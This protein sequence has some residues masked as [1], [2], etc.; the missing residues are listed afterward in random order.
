MDD[1]ELLRLASQL[2]AALK[3]RGLKMTLAESCT[4]G[5]ASQF[6]TAVAGSSAWFDCGFVTYSNAAK[7][8]LLGVPEATLI[9]H[10]AVSEQTAYAMALGAISN[11]RAD[12]AASITGIAGPSGGTATKPIGTVCFAF[13][14]KNRQMPE[15]A[16]TQL[17]H[18]AANQTN[19]QVI[20]RTICFTGN[21]D[22]IRKQSVTQTLESLITLTL[23]LDL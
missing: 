13:A 4:G 18:L 19:L 8:H 2:G 12:I 20:T 16:N 7:Q 17:S 14:F 1:D 6:V 11:S 15:A 9:E 22:A 23:S 21:R 10:G 5:M 3:S